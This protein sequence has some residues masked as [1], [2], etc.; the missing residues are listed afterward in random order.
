MRPLRQG[1]RRLR[2]RTQGRLHRLLPDQDH[3]L[4]AEGFDHG[5]YLAANPDVAKAGMEPLTHFLTYGWKEGRDPRPDFSVRDYAE[6]NPDV[7]LSG[8][9]PFLPYLQ[10]GQA[11][12][13]LARH[14]LGFRHDVLADLPS[15]DVRLQRAAARWPQLRPTSGDPLAKALETS[16]SG[17][18]DL[19]VSVSHDDYTA[20]LGGLQICVQREAAG[21]AAQ[22]IDHLHLF[23]V[24]TFP[25]LRTGPETSLIGGLWN[26][27]PIGQFSAQT[28]A[29]TLGRCLPKAGRRSLALHSLLGHS[30]SDILQITEAL[31]I[32]SGVFWL[33]DFAS[34]CA[35]FHLL[36][37]DVADCGAP[38][39]ESPAC[40]VCIYKPRRSLHVEEHR[41]IFEALAL[42]VLAP[43]ASALETWSQACDFPRAGAYVR[44]HASLVPG[45]PV[46][47]ASPAGPLK[48]AFVGSPVPHK[49]WPVFQ[50]LARRFA[51]DSRYA[52]LHFGPGGAGFGNISAHAVKVTSDQP[53]AMRDALDQEGV[54]IA[55]VWPLCR[56]TFSFTAYEAVAAGAVVLTGPDSGNV[57]DFIETGGHGRVLADEAALI[58]LFDSGEALALSRAQRRPQLY[59]LVFSSLTAEPEVRPG[60]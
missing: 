60:S 5:F 1:L 20:H 53:S 23:P 32:R 29:E 26:G 14:D 33:H 58:G 16:R 44:P 9:N 41:R 39:P 12:G 24:D 4:L 3:R 13:R 31:E 36:R 30:S 19:H 28:L 38:P 45:D 6:L 49:G 18:S 40:G 42:T 47:V 25:T 50:E 55:L 2:E 54:D 52:F 59:D 8:Q 11:E 34:L 22:G 57:A 7:G 51:Q 27:H 10:S 35:G 37:N 46:E 43:S 48:I 56:E 17:L 15:L 21:L